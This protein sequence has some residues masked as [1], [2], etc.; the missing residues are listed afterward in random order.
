MNPNS[1]NRILFA[2]ALFAVSGVAMAASSAAQTRSERE[3]PAASVPP[4]PPFNPDALWDLT[5]LVP[6]ADPD[7]GC[8]YFATISPVS[9][10][11]NLRYTADGQ[12]MCPGIQGA[13]KM[14][15]QESE[16]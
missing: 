5:K 14:H 12:P 4:P 15:L 16:R 2:C 7:S 9:V 11:L 13:T 3:R 8:K 6:W 1:Y 10:T